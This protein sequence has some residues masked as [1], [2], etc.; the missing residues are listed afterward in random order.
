VLGLGLAVVV[1]VGFGLSLLLTNFSDK[2]LSADFYK[3]TIAA[4]DTYNR[5]YDEVLVDDKLKE[6]SA[7]FLGDIK[8]VSHQEI[9]DLLRE[10]MPPEYIQQE[11]EGSIDRTVDYINDDVETLEAYV[12]LT[13]SLDNVKPVMF[14]YLE[15]KIDELEVIDPGTISCSLDG[16]TDPKLA[17]LADDYIDQF[18]SMADGEVPLAVP[19]LN[20]LEPLCREVLFAGFYDSLLSSTELPAEVTRSLREQRGRLKAPFQAGETLE[21]LKVASKLLTE[22]LIDEAVAQV[23]QNLKEGDRFDLIYQLGQWDNESSEAQIR[24]D[25]ADGRDFVSRA[26]GFGDIAILIMMYGGT[27][28]MALVF[29]PKLSSMLRWPGIVLFITGLF[30]FIAGKILESKVPDA[31]ADVVQTGA[32]KVSDVPPSVTDLGGDILIS[33]GLQMTD[34]FTGPAMSILVIGAIMFGASFFTIFFGRF[35]PFLK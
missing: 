2:L 30:Y 8:V 13:V 35:I 18:T 20:V 6:K 23:R 14:N 1:F 10:I 7:E 31:L 5:I 29:F 17:N 4:Q 9:V 34:G 25:I 28:L 21:V 32:G 12:D 19:S 22:P 11:V 15:T 24:S 3:D 33:F 16:L 26:R 27:V